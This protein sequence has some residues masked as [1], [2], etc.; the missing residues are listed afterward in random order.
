MRHYEIVFLIHPDQSDQVPGIIERYEG[1]IAKHQGKIHRKEDWGRKQL[2]YEIQDVHKAH[3]LLLNIEC[4]DDA[5]AELKNLIK[6]NDAILRHL[7]VREK[8]AITAESPMMRKE[9][10]HRENKGE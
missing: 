8:H 1:V 10:E 9:K 7:I 2:A 3:Y 6:F 5:M 4:N